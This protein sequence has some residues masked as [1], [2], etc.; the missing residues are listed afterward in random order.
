MKKR[1]SFGTYLTMQAAVY[2]GSV[3]EAKKFVNHI[4]DCNNAEY[5]EQQEITPLKIYE[6]KPNGVSVQ[7][8]KDRCKHKR[9]RSHYIHSPP[10]YKLTCLDC[11][12][13]DLI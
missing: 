6:L 3:E 5:V 11:D 2:R 7:E 10:F 9:T 13:M 4:L 1:I 8:V 12:E